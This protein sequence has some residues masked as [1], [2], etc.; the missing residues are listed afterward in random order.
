MPPELSR[1]IADLRDTYSESSIAKY[2]KMRRK[3]LVQHI[4][5]LYPR[6]DP[7]SEA[8][9]GP[10]QRG[11][12]A[13]YDSDGGVVTGGAQETPDTYYDE[14]LGQWL[15]LPPDTSAAAQQDTAT[16]LLP[17]ASS[18]STYEQVRPGQYQEAQGYSQSA[19]RYSNWQ[20]PYQVEPDDGEAGE[21][22]GHY[23]EPHDPADD[24]VGGSGGWE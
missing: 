10:S 5:G 22:T 21:P 19:P 23:R 18:S 24:G 3:A 8:E 4:D 17:G 14:N 20:N 6:N 11:G 7:E 13:G 15:P 9:A 12:E 2:L 16:A 1:R